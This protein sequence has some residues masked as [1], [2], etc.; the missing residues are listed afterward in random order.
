MKVR[1]QLLAIT[2]LYVTPFVSMAQ[3]VVPY[4][5]SEVKVDWVRGTDFSKY[6]TYAC[7]MRPQNRTAACSAATPT[8]VD[9]SGCPS[10][11]CSSGP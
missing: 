7:N 3:D 4:A 11:C 1:C 10:T 2:V 9:L 5:K 8:G 6:K